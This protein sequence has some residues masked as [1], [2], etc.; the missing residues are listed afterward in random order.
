[1][2]KMVPIEYK[3]AKHIVSFDGKNQPTSNNFGMQN[4]SLKWQLSLKFQCI[5]EYYDRVKL[6]NS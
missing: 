3:N 2:N 4:S 6:V 5:K 1:M